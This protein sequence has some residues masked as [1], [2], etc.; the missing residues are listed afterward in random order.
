MADLTSESTVYVTYIAASPE[1]VWAA[2]TSSE[3]T[4]RY[5][6]G[7]A[8]ESDWKAGS[9]WLLRT[10]AG[11]VDVE[12]LVRAS[13]PPRK[14]VLGWRVTAHPDLPECVVTYEIEPVGEGAV[15]L[16]MTE[17]HPTPIPPTF[18]TAAAAAGP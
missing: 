4:T 1:K 15:R 17:A 8:M 18:S 10:P 16:T 7:R 3:F 5:F 6:F 11:A 14:L 9:P 2:L 12:G 13:D